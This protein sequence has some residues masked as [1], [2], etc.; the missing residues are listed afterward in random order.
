MSY[1]G[2]TSDMLT[3]IAAQQMKVIHLCVLYLTQDS[4]QQTI[5]MTDSG[6]DI[7]WNGQTYSDTEGLT[8][9]SDPNESYQLDVDSASFTLSGTELANLS[10]ALTSNFTDARF[11]IRRAIAQVESSPM[12]VTDPVVIWDGR[13]DSWEYSETP[14]QEST[15]T[16]NMSNH[17]VDFTRVSGRRTNSA[18]QQLFYPGDLG[19]DYADKLPSTIMWPGFYKIPR[20]YQGPP[21]SSVPISWGGYGVV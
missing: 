8:D 7:V 12:V 18:D 15:L 21:L 16:W 17:W 10:I 9:L 13:I 2:M 6:Q 3:A 4:P 19:L 11:V 14:G 5:Y 20:G 1:R